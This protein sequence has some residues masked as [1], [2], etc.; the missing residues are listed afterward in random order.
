MTE[1]EVF[2]FV[3]VAIGASSGYHPRILALRAPCQQGCA[4]MRVEIA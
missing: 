2:R 1:S 4:Y 3:A